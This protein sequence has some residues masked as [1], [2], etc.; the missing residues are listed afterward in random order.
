MLSQWKPGRVG[1][2][3]LAMLASTSTGNMLSVS[4][5]CPDISNRS[6]DWEHA[7]VLLGSWLNS[8]RWLDKDVQLPSCPNA[9]SRMQLRTESAWPKKTNDRTYS[10]DSWEKGNMQL[11]HYQKKTRKHKHEAQTSGPQIN[12]ICPTEKKRIISSEI[13]QN[14]LK[15]WWW[16]SWLL[17]SGGQ[18]TLRFFLSYN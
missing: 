7:C 16:C 1:K 17:T 12:S 11:I 6:F 10:A 8:W 18:E 13:D 14:I 3:L 2:G 9:G 15:K 4:K 5:C